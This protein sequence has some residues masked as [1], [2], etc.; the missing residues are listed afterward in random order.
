MDEAYC[1]VHS[2][3][4]PGEYVLVAVSDTG[5]GM[6]PEVMEHLFDPFFTTKEVGKGT[7]LG[8]AM[9]YG[10]M[11]QNNGHVQVYSE[12]WKGTTVNLYL[13]RAEEE[14]PKPEE[15]TPDK[16]V[17]R[18][19][20]TILVAEDELALLDTC[21]YVL[22]RQGYT[23]L[24][25]QDP[26]EALEIAEKHPGEID[27]LLTDVV[28]PNM[29]GKK[30]AKELRAMCPHL[31]T[32]FMSGYTADVMAQHGILHQEMTFIQKPFTFTGLAEKVREVLDKE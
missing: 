31:K 25:A 14:G 27:L 9:V 2:G 10:V 5:E 8:L 30:L 19:E 7:G 13:P 26:K 32:L 22:V 24:A 23:V 12:P 16:P 11:K 28:M 29:D 18:G 17:P 6:A 4:E 1:E 21:R 3:V 20:E 15:K